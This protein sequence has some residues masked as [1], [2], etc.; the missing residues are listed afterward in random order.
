MKTT[1]P[2]ILAAAAFA[3]ASA[4]TLRSDDA[5]TKYAPLTYAPAGNHGQALV[6]MEMA[7]HVEL[8]LIT[9]HVTPKGVAA[10]S[11]KDRCIMF[12]TIGRIGKHDNQEDIDVFKAGQE[13]T[14]VATDPAPGVPSWSP[15][16]TPKFEVMEPML[17]SSGSPVGLAVI[18]FAY[19]AGDDTDKF[20]KAARKIRDEI[21]ARTPS[22]DALFDPAS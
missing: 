4:S 8:K 2:C 5:S 13:K 6:D 15:T 7:K 20:T 10:D 11:D 19:K 17:D 12:S 1:L 18:V 22:K 16:S 9:L 3:C 14:E 21:K